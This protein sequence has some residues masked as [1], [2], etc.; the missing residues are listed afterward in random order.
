MFDYVL[1]LREG[2]VDAWS[3][4]IGAMKSSDKTALLA[5]Y[6]DSIFNLLNIIYVDQ[7]KGDN[8]MR[9]TMGVIGDIASAFPNGEY[10]HYFRSDWLAQMIKETRQNRDFQPRTIETAKW[11][12]EQS[13]RQT[14]GSSS[15]F[16]A[17][18]T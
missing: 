9:A 2:I 18:T 15:A 6:V 3:G 4:I 7:N 16:Q 14:G 17:H 8:L 5:P 1:S 10:Q 12:R 13:K 11:A